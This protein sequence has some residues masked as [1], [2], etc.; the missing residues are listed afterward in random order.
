MEEIYDEGL[1]VFSNTNDSDKKCGMCGMVYIIS[2][3]PHDCLTKQLSDMRKFTNEL[4]E[5][6]IAL[7][8]E[9]DLLHEQNLI[10]QNAL[11]EY[12]NTRNAH[13]M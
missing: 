8:H 2:H 5:A 10:L 3:S 12:E 11:N 7:T 6:N 9:N 4:C 13:I 1:S